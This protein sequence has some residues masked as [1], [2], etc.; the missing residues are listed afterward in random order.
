MNTEDT[1]KT[2]GG[3][4]GD[5]EGNAGSSGTDSQSKDASAA[6]GQQTGSPSTSPTE[7]TEFEIDGQ[8]YTSDQIREF[9][10]AYRDYQALQSE[11]TRRSQLLAK[12][13]KD[14]VIDEYG[15]LVQSRIPARED[16]PLAGNPQAQEAVKILKDLGF[17]TKEEAEELR[18]AIAELQQSFQ[19]TTGEAQLQTVVKTLSEKYSGKNGEPP[20]NLEDIRA[21]IQKDPSLIVYVKGQNDEYLVDLEQT[22]KKVHADFWDKLPSL[23]AK[24]VKTER[25]VGVQSAP[26]TVSKKAETEEERAATAMEFFRN[27]KVEE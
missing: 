26:P 18:K 13:V 21:A 23:K 22:Y 8:K 2:P 24:G 15:N 3:F 6:G 9:A 7:P 14:G 19:L 20:F 10:K 5:S 12:L 16:N 11:F 4:S 25:G 1:F 17:I 27:Q